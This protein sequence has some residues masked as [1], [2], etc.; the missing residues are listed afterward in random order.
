M[1]LNRK[2]V[3]RLEMAAKTREWKNLIFVIDQRWH[4]LASAIIIFSQCNSVEPTGVTLK[5][6]QMTYTMI[7]VH[8]ST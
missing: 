8:S 6:R 7:V 2:P 4:K 3:F 1:G 5:M